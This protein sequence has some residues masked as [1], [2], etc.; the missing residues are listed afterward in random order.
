M[1]T[2]VF[3]LIAALLVSGAVSAAEGAKSSEKAKAKKPR[4]TFNRTANLIY[5]EVHG[6]GLLVDVFE[7]RRNANGLAIVDVVSG[8]WFSDKGKLNDHM[9]AGI[10]RIFC[11]RGFTVF[12]IRPGSVTKFSG[13]E[14]VDNVHRGIAWVKGRATKYGINRDRL[15]IVGASAGAHLSLMAITTAHKPNPKVV[16]KEPKFD[17]SI[18]AAG[19]FFPPTDFVG[20]G[21]K[22]VQREYG[23]LFVEGGFEGLSDE[24]VTEA[25]RALSPALLVEQ[26]PPP[27]LLIHGDADKVVPIAQ[28]E[29]MI[30]AL[31]AAGGEAEL[32]VKEG[33]EHPWPTI[34]E[35]VAVLAD[36]FEKKL[37]E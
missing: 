37:V 6:V 35:E 23:R 17:L 36:Y 21:S 20:W 22:R 33:G 12:A 13:P 18:R 28:S 3:T 32:I 4:P 26:T 29:T 16:G 19:L 5:G 8:A 24:A 30:A 10:Y 9:K 31:K 25:M 27:V 7:P 2:V 34:H 11:E 15:G 14:M 1:R